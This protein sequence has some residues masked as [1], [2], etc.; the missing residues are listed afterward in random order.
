MEGE[1]ERRGGG[2]IRATVASPVPAVFP[3]GPLR[4][5]WEKVWS[6]MALGQGRVAP[7]SCHREPCHPS[8]PLFLY[9]CGGRIAAADTPLCGTFRGAMCAASGSGGSGTSSC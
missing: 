1:E 8:N 4:R 7:L 5:K 3:E 9:A 6:T 2:G